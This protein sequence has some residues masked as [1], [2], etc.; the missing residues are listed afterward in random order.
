MRHKTQ[1]QT[2]KTLLDLREQGRDQEMLENVVRLPVE[3]YTDP[4]IYERELD[5]VFRNAPTVAGHACHVQEPG[6]YLLSD[7]DTF[8]YVI[9]RG[10]DGKLRGFLNTCRHRGA[11][12]VSGEKETLNAFV[13]PYHGW[14][15]GLD[16]CLL[17]VTEEH[18]F[19]DLDYDEYGLVELS[20][21]ERAGLVWIHPTPGKPID[22][23]TYLGPF[24]DDLDHFGLDNL[25]SYKKHVTT[26]AAN[27]KLLI[28]TYLEGYHVPYLHNQQ[29]SKAFRNGVIA[30]RE[31][32]PHIRLAA[33]RSNVLNVR[34]K[35]ESDWNILDYASVYYT[36][37][38]NTFFIMHPDYVSINKFYP[39]APNRTIWTHDMLYRPPDFEGEKGDNALKRRFEFTNDVVFDAE[40]FSI[41]EDVQTGLRSGAN[42]EHTLGLREGLLAIFQEN[43]DQFIHAETA[44]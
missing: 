19:P 31:H 10:R 9:V 34:E 26:K 38:P 32:G 4:E 37:F 44:A 5:T 20:V 35:D 27:W 6:D 7:W 42:D 17:S 24:A 8:P 21:A 40:D 25:V 41:A 39:E 2:L 33:A 16:G 11:K 43:I 29:F 28:K 1:V 18:T 22:L 30:H 36:F 14:A 12:I 13:C 23:D 3:N 15:Y